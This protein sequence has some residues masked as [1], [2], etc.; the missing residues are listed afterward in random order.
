MTV[1]KRHEKRE[2]KN[3]N[4]NRKNVMK[5][6]MVPSTKETSAGQNTGII[7][8]LPFWNKICGRCVF[9]VNDK[10]SL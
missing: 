10:Q 7:K 8:L 1:K 3:K 2:K 5:S 6:P 9:E 4:I